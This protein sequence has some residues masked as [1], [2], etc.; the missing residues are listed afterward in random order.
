M[1]TTLADQEAQLEQL[2]KSGNNEEAIKLLSKL[3]SVCAEKS[4]FERAEAFRDQMYEVDSMA[5]SEIVNVNKSIETFKSKALTP[6]H[7]KLWAN[8]FNHLTSEEANAFFFALKE[9]H[10]DEEKMILQQGEPNERLYLISQGKLKI[11]HE[12]QDK[13]MLIHTLG[14]GDILGEDTF[15]S[16]NVCTVS[17]KSLSKVKLSY[18][19]RDKLEGITIQYPELESKLKKN[20]RHR[21]KNCRVAAAKR[22]GSPGVQTL[23]D[24]DRRLVRSTDTR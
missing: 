2:I 16:I 11:V 23:C 1:P 22:H 18:L 6:D 17:A 3:A 9:L 13:Q 10:L 20:L 5:L 4:D 12:R 19:Q 24:T 8:F 14:S 21:G 15:F 7:R